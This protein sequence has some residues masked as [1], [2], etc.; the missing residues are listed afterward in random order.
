VRG[1][2]GRGGN[3][4]RFGGKDHR[5]Q[6]GG[7]GMNNGGGGSMRYNPTPSYAAPPPQNH[8]WNGAPQPPRYIQPPPMQPPPVNPAAS[9]KVSSGDWIILGFLYSI[10]TCTFSE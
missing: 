8:Y 4:N 2:R 9:Q 7:N 3:V 6:Y 5:V 10:L 1:T